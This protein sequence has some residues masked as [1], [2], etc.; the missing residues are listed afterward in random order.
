MTEASVDRPL[1]ADFVAMPDYRA[2]SLT[3]PLAVQLTHLMLSC[4]WNLAGV[5]LLSR[6]LAALGPTASMTTVAL[7]VGLALLMVIG[8][9]KQPYLYLAS[10]L[11]AMTG[12][13]AAIAGAFSLNPSLWPSEIWRY[14]G[15]GLNCLALVGGFW[16]FTRIYIAAKSSDNYY[17]W[18]S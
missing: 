1:R 2:P 8:A 10:S 3:A 14:A 4:V 7:L 9:K 12:A 15:V 11:V 17:L 16:G 13:S 5:Y 18:P 6:D